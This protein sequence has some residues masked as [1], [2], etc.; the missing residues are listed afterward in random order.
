MVDDRHY[1]ADRLSASEGE[2]GLSF[3]VVIEGVRAISD[4]FFLV[5]SQRGHPIRIAAIDFPGQLE[6]L[7]TLGAR[8]DWFDNKRRRHQGCGIILAA[9]GAIFCD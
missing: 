5:L 4:Q 1:T 9:V 3:G 8:L 7:F 2:E 6:E